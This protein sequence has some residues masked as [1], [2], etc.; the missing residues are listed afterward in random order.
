LH[1]WLCRKA[2]TKATFSVSHIPK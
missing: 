2:K 1:R